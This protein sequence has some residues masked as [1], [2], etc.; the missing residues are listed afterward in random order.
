[1]INDQD[2]PRRHLLVAEALL[3]EGSAAD[4]RYDLAVADLGLGPIALDDT[5]VA[6]LSHRDFTFRLLGLKLLEIHGILGWPVPP[7]YRLELDYPSG[8]ATFGPPGPPAADP[9][10]MWLGTPF[11]RGAVDGHEALVL[12]DTGATVTSLATGA[13]E[14]GIPLPA[15]TLGETVVGGVG[16]SATVEIERI[17]GPRP[18]RI[19]RSPAPS[20]TTSTSPPVRSSTVVS[21]P[22]SG[23]PR[24][25]TRSSASPNRAW[26]S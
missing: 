4:A 22:G 25:S 17:P 24:S 13:R 20:R 5:A 10:L 14:R 9:D 23:T 11:V 21:V 15:G 19:E 2:L 3:A 7:R 16:G 8:T 26:T 6:V 18:Q 1:M 12:L